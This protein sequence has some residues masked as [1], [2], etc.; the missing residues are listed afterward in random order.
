MAPKQEQ[1]EGWCGL[2]PE[3]AKGKM[4][5]Q[6]YEPKPFEE[7]DVDIEISHCG[8]CGSDLH[9]LSS[10]W[11]PTPYP[12]VVGHE[13]VGKATRVG[14]DVK[15][16]IK[17]GDRVGVGAQSGSCLRG[18]CE[19]CQNDL[20]EHCQNEM[21]NTYGSK[22]PSGQT[23]MGGYAK[24][25]RGRGH[26]VFKIPD[27]IPSEM[28]APMLCGGVTVYS[29]L[30]QN[31]C[32]P[33]KRVGIVGVGGLG[34]FGI[35][36]AKALGASKVVAISRNSKKK[37]D[38]MR[39]GADELIATEEDKDWA[40]KNANSLDLIISTVYTPKLPLADYLTLLDIQGTFIQVGAPV[41]FCSDRD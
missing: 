25:W 28:A 39:M 3:S 8:V 33:G 12:V 27:S 40:K 30:V 34:H 23:S 29:P 5:W 22:W 2:G 26:F 14:K 38:A 32:G 36:F 7:S 16:G 19:Q 13:I 20:E 35:L 41:R 15:S 10:G 18:D 11:G 9:V 6:G 4:V 1:F 24:Y 31:G 37:E 21:V 17:V